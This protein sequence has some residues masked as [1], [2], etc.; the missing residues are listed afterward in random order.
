M[1]VPV[2]ESGSTQSGPQQPG[3]SLTGQVAA[4]LSPVKVEENTLVRP[5]GELYSF[6]GVEMSTCRSSIQQAEARS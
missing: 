6:L 5:S 1:G 3:S 2:D 4:V